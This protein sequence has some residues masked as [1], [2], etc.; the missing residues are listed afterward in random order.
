M[1][2]DKKL[3]LELAK[4]YYKLAIKS[5]IGFYALLAL[6]TYFYWDYI[7]TPVLL[8]LVA[9]SYLIATIFLIA[10]YLFKRLGTEDNAARWLRIFTFL[11]LLNDIPWGLIGPI[12]YSI[13]IETYQMLTLFMLAGITAG[14]IITRASVLKNYIISLIAILLPISITLAVE[15]SEKSI[16][17]LCMILIYTLFLLSAAKEYSTTINRNIRLWLDNETLVTELRN[18]N[19]EVEEAR[20]RAEQANIAKS[21]FLATISHE[22]RTPLNGIIGFTELLQGEP[23]DSKYKKSVDQIE[24]AGKSLLY[25]VNDILDITAIEAGHIH[26]NKESF[27]LSKEMQDLVAMLQPVAQKKGLDFTLMVDNDV[28]DVI[29]GDISRIR[30]IVGNLLSNGLK[31]TESG[32]VTLHISTKEKSS[33]YLVLNFD[34]KDSGIGIPTDKLSS[35]FENFT[36]LESFETRQNEGTG[37]GLAIVKNL[38]NRMDG[39][40]HVR[41]EVAQGTCFSL[42]LTFELGNEN[43]LIEEQ[44][45]IN[46]DIKLHGLKVLIVDDND[47]NRRLLNVFLTRM[48]ATFDEAENGIE[49]LKLIRK[50]QYDVVLLDIQMPDITGLEVATIV[51]KEFAFPPILIAITA[52]AFPEQRNSILEAGFTDFLS[53]P[54]MMNVLTN[55][56]LKIYEEKPNNL[57]HNKETLNQHGR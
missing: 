51:L 34:I 1:T 47:I 14:G 16:I 29:R 50:E 22:L 25:I 18:S 24:K 35:I 3:N 36:R 48:G 52:H 6:V 33:N 31:Y 37:L 17:M 43:E 7:S 46:T 2:V 41:S 11:S 53:K 10:A 39:Q 15:N 44:Q 9:F 49:A 55:M 32:Y 12:G 45:P 54:V 8:S 21:Q 19:T 56:L 38:V 57:L 20:E 28:E 4:E 42:V 30:Q 27:S 23:L 5:S 13:E 40:L 26:I